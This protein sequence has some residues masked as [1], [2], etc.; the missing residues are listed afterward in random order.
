MKGFENEI[1]RYL[2]WCSNLISLLILLVAVKWPRVARLVFLIL[3]AWA[4]WM[5]WTTVVE[6]PQVYLTYADLAWSNT[7]REFING[8]FKEHMLLSVRFIAFC[9][10][11]IAVSMP[12]GGRIFKTGAAGAI[13]FLL[14]IIPLGMGSGFPATLLMATAVLIIVKRHA[15]QPLWAGARI[16]RNGIRHKAI[17]VSYK[18]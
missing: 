18:K 2:L 12:A 3:F 8:W 13:V 4:A 7:Y 14:A 6:K 15:N 17:P 5:N 9:Q 10:G 1:Y 11:L 16:S